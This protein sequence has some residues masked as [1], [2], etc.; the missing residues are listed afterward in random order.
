[1][2]AFKKIAQEIANK[3]DEWIKHHVGERI[4]FV[5]C[6]RIIDVS[7]DDRGHY[8]IEGEA[9]EQLPKVCIKKLDIKEPDGLI[10]AR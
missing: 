9:E 4:V 7:D 5:L 6:D 8:H 2:I 3:K 1:M 10:A